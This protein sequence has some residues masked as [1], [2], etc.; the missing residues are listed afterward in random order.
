MEAA[1]DV[2]V[3]VHMD[4]AGEVTHAPSDAVAINDSASFELARDLHNRSPQDI[5]LALNFFTA[6]MQIL[7][8]ALTLYQIVHGQ[9]PSQ[10]QIIQ[11]FNQT[12]NVIHQ[13]TINA[14]P[15]PG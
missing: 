7:Q 9:P 14:P 11:I 4:A 13:T 12:T 3:T 2:G 8:T 6:I 10:Q 15:P 5:D 1:G